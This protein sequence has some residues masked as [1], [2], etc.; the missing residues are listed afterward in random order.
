MAR[1]HL[2][3]EQTSDGVEQ[4]LHVHEVITVALTVRE[5]GESLRD[6]GHAQRPIDACSHS[7]QWSVL[8]SQSPKSFDGLLLSLRPRHRFLTAMQRNHLPACRN[9]ARHRHWRVDASGHQRHSSA[10][11]LSSTILGTH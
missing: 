3:G 4:P 9:H 11:H 2:V 7:L 8:A 1:S 6:R 10:D 5:Q